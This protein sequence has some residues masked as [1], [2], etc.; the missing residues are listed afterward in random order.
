LESADAIC[1]D[2]SSL[3][4]GKLENISDLGCELVSHD[5][6]DAPK[7]ALNSALVLNVLDGKGEKAMN[8][9]ASVYEVSQHDG[10]WVYHIRWAHRPSF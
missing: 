2:F 9:R 4:S 8:V 3:V 6:S 7:L 5:H 1:H 10:I